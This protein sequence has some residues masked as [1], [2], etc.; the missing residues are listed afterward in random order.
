MKVL[1]GNKSQ[2]CTRKSQD[3]LQPQTVEQFRSSFK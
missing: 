2:D 1:T 3:F